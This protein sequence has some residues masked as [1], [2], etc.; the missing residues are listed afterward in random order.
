[1]LYLRQGIELISAKTFGA[2]S[3]LWALS[4]CS[5]DWGL[6]SKQLYQISFSHLILIDKVDKKQVLSLC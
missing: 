1:M 3:S 6:A 4:Q 2:S 5:L